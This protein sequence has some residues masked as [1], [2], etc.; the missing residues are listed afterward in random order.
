MKELRAL[1]YIAVVALLSVS[2]G[3]AGEPARP[4]LSLSEALNEAF[5]RSPVLRIAGSR[6]EQ[7]ESRLRTAKIYPFNP[8]LTVDAAR[9]EGR[10]ETNTDTGVK[11]AQEIQIGG[12]RRRDAAQAS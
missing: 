12:Q 11:L 9:R 10:V 8:E 4:T 6:V 7:A 5:A 1:S 3:L 2:G